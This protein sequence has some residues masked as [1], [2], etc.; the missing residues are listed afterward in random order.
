MIK[1]KSLITEKKIKI[2]SDISIIDGYNSIG[3]SLYKVIPQNKQSDFFKFLEKYK[4]KSQDIQTFLDDSDEDIKYSDDVVIKFKANTKADRENPASTREFYFSV[5]ASYGVLR[6][7]AG[8]KLSKPEQLTT[9]QVI[10]QF[11]KKT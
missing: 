4:N 6:I 3:T 5:Y 7:G 1:L 11:L 9:H 2:T 8:G 10:E